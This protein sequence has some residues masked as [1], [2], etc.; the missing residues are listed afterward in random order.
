MVDVELKKRGVY[1]GK[2]GETG[3]YRVWLDVSA[4]DEEYEGGVGLLLYTDPKG[5]TAPMRTVKEFDGEKTKLYGYVTAEETKE[6]G[7]GVIEARWENAGVV[8]KSD[9]FN[10]VVMASSYTGK[11][12]GE[13]TPDW[14]RDLMTEL[15]AVNVVLDEAAQVAEDVAAIRETIEG[16]E[17]VAKAAAL[18][19]EAWAVGERD[20]EDVDEDDPTYGN[21]ARK[22]AQDAGGSATFAQ[23]ERQTAEA[24]AVGKRNGQDVGST[25]PAYHNNA[26]Y[27]AEQAF[28]GTP[29]GYAAL[30]EDVGDAKSAVKLKANI[31]NVSQITGNEEIVFTDG[32]YIKTDAEPVNPESIVPHGTYGYAVLE[33]AAGDVFYID[34]YGGDVAKAYTFINDDGD[35]LE[36][37]TSYLTQKYITAPAN[38][39]KLVLNGAKTRTRVCA[40]GKLLKDEVADIKAEVDDNYAN[41]QTMDNTI[42]RGVKQITGNDIVPMLES[43]YI[44][45]NG[46]TANTDNITVNRNYAHV[47]IDCVPGDKHTITGHGGST[48]R[49]WAYLG[50]D[51]GGGDRPVITTYRANADEVALDIVITAPATAE[52]LVIN[53]QI[54]YDYAVC[55]GDTLHNLTNFIEQNTEWLTGNHMINLYE[56]G[57]IVTNGDTCDVNT[58]TANKNYRHIV[59]DCTPGDQFTITGTGGSSSRLWAFAG[60]E[61][62]GTRPVIEKSDESAAVTDEVLTAPAGAEK[63]IINLLVANA[64]K[65]CTGVAAKIVVESVKNEIHGTSDYTVLETTITNGKWVSYINNINNDAGSCYT[66][67]VP[68]IPGRTVKLSNLYLQYGRAVCGYGPDKSFDSETGA[69]ISQSNATEHTFIV[70]D[71]IYYIRATGRANV[72]PIIQQSAPAF[73]DLQDG[74]SANVIALRTPYRENIIN[75]KIVTLIDDDLQNDTAVGHYA[76][77]FEALSTERGV[78][79]RCTFAA[80]AKM[81]DANN[82]AYAATAPAHIEFVKSLQARGFHIA[83][84]TY[85]HSRWYGDSA[86]GTMFALSECNQDLIKSIEVLD[87]VGLIDAGRYLVYT[88]SSGTRAGIPE[89]AKKWCECAATIVTGNNLMDNSSRFQ[90]HR[91]Y[92]DAT[93]H[94]N[95]SWYQ[96]Q[97]TDLEKDGNN[98]IIYYTHCKDG[99]ASWGGNGNGKFDPDLVKDVLENAL[100]NGWTMMTYRE[101]W[102]YRKAQYMIQEAFGF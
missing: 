70:P 8:A 73:D 60:T 55:A 77:F 95:V 1:L 44:A 30:V 4:W 22:Y 94:D 7:T 99:P 90:L 67:Y 61:S 52:K 71:G 10:T 96:Q 78:D 48:P 98:W 33:C 75:R 35:I 101:A 45:T 24:W 11:N 29:E 86:D 18:D 89:I 54:A 74:Y 72:A 100:D 47:V 58:V 42:I 28:S 6:A 91:C 23:I 93:W 64:H 50:A 63:L 27:Y 65:L 82:P 3:R 5:N 76:D 80:I 83:N 25:D 16:A 34:I 97:L 79:L 53:V 26:K 59:L 40:T 9:H 43:G 39:T 41:A 2:T 19:S 68:V 69:I 87:K 32:G 51:A 84:H 46:S 92:I 13:N 12:I 38:A 81:L 21:N 20:G 66:D 62:G 37:S 17:T 85:D 57:Y 31:T 15:N 14:V 56:S 102:N 36:S 49:L 88:G